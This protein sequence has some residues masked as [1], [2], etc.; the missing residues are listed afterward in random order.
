MVERCELCG[1]R[2]DPESEVCRECGAPLPQTVVAM[3]PPPPPDLDWPE[4]EPTVVDEALPVVPAEDDPF[5]AETAPAV[6]AADAPAA[7]VMEAPVGP[8]LAAPAAASSMADAIAPSASVSAASISNAI[9]PSASVSAASLSSA[10]PSGAVPS[11]PSG[12]MLATPSAA[13]DVAPTRRRGLLLA[14]A[15]GGLVAA[16]VGIV[17]MPGSSS[18]PAESGETPSEPPGDQAPSSSSPSPAPSSA[19]PELEALAGSWVFT[20]F[21][22]SARNKKRLGMRHYFELEIRVS[23]CEAEASLVNTGRHGAKVYEDD[24]KQHATATLARGEGARSFGYGAL[25]EPRN[26]AGQGI[27]R[28]ITFAVDGERLVGA[29]QEAGE[30]WERSGQLGVIE[31]R[32]RGDPREWRPH[33]DTMPCLV[34]CAVPK[35]IEE[36]DAEPDPAAIEACRAA[37]E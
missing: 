12:A 36:A 8:P 5:L 30:H 33:R 26:A 17:V 19:C 24:R 13:I 37:C 10:A 34:Q 15:A 31:G 29:W 2:W 11:M 23:D 28:Q 9:A 3:A 14:L 22:T 1:A 4:P 18:T 32:R 35:T 25:F 16:V 21:T 6:A 7:A 20:T 27:P